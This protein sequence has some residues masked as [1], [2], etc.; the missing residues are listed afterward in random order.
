MLLTQ[1]GKAVA[2]I[3]TRR[4]ASS[5]ERFAAREL[6]SYVRK[7]SGAQLPVGASNPSSSCVHV[8][9][10]EGDDATG[11]EPESFR[12]IA[13]RSQLRIVGADDRGTLYGVYT[14]IHD[15]LG[16]S[17]VRYHQSEETIPRRATIR[18][19]AMHRYDKPFLSERRMVCGADP[20]TKAGK[21]FIAWA[22]KNRLNT[23]FAECGEAGAQ[24][25]QEEAARKRGLQ[26]VWGGHQ[27]GG[28]MPA[29]KYFNAHPEYFAL[30]DGKRQPVSICATNPAVV[31]LH[32]RKILAFTR[33]Y[34]GIR[35]MG[36]WPY[37]GWEWCECKK[38]AALEPK[39]WYSPV[40]PIPLTGK[41]RMHTVR[42]LKF[43]NAVI[44]RVAA[45]RPDVRFELIAYWATVEPPPRP[46]DFKIHPNANLQVALIERM[47][48]RPLAHKLTAPER[49]ALN[50]DLHYPWDSN[51][52]NHYPRMLRRWRKVFPGPIYFY[53]Y[54]TA[55]LGCLSCLFPMM[56]TIR[57]DSRF[58]HKLG[59]QGFGTQGWLHNW[60]AYGL[61]YWY[62]PQAAWDG[63]ASHKDF[64]AQY[65]DEYFGRAGGE[66]FHIYRALEKSFARHR[67]GLPLRQIVQAFDPATMRTCDEH[68]GQA[69]RQAR[70]QRTKARVE[71]LA[72]LLEYGQKL[73]LISKAG[74]GANASLERGDWKGCYE[75]LAAQLQHQLRVM[76]LMKGDGVFSDYDRERVQHFFVG[77]GS[78]WTQNETGLFHLF[79]KLQPMESGI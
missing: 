59:A 21:D 68:L 8:G 62:A 22:S 43:A 46:L 1:S 73:H 39:P 7:I 70:D 42:Y 66:V 20:R 30:V 40:N 31:D 61:S 71:E 74:A 55:S 23:V 2:K 13:D 52:Y 34:P 27:F 65:C 26:V 14:F 76:E 78:W 58:Y 57:Q 10:A 3:Q 24:R 45:K 38:C 6:A 41:M 16:V 12:I 63:N 50:A 17:W 9:I 37:D 51:K 18:V 35:V 32:V 19:P 56:Y 75:Q 5:V 25:M 36:F 79:K 4:A 64:L 15:C 44:A 29:D 53:E 48:D 33:K 49:K 11:M 69:R 60:A 77:R 47:Y 67:I 54:Y 72:I 28:W